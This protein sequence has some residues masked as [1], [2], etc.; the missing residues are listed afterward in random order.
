MASSD[1]DSK[2]ALWDCDFVVYR[3]GFAAE[4]DP[5]WV[6][7]ARV[8]E[9]LNEVTYM[10]LD[11]AEYKAYLTGKNNFRN[12]IAVTQPYK[13]N[14]KDFVK[15]KHYEAIRNHLI[16]LGAVVTEGQE[17]DDA[18][19]IEMTNYPDKYILVGQDKDLLQIPGEHYNPVKKEF[20][21]I[22]PE[23][24]LRNFYT[25]ILTGD[26]TD[27][28]LG[29]AGI[30]PVKAKK[31]LDKCKTPYEMWEACVKAHDSYDRA[32]EDAR[33]LYLRRKEGELWQPPLSNTVA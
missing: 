31:I 1:K 10:E 14:R 25:Q 5:E 17:A 21:T 9:F 16:R 32:L 12:E 7:L 15:P 22:T 4:D 30:G 29:V 2:V 18:V 20:T 3:V 23:E 13:G 26:R 28:I 11:C 33:L 24:G 6:A 8:T 27:A 19:A